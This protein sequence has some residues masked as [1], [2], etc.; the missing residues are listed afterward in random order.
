MRNAIAKIKNFYGTSLC[1][2][3]AAGAGHALIAGVAGQCCVGCE[4]PEFCGQVN[5]CPHPGRSLGGRRY[6]AGRKVRSLGPRQPRPGHRLLRHD[7]TSLRYS[8]TPSAS[9][10]QQPRVC[11]GA[12]VRLRLK[13]AD[14]V[15]LGDSVIG[16][17]CPHA[18]T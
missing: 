17:A 8:S 3:V 5:R 11:G 14:A 2:E 1:A 9:I 7:T 15:G 13:A 12:G 6:G 10:S 18:R 16:R 4:P